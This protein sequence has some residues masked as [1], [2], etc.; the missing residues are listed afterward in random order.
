MVSVP[1]SFVTIHPLPCSFHATR[2]L[3]ASCLIHLLLF[4]PIFLVLSVQAP[5]TG[6]KGLGAKALEKKL[7]PNVLTFGNAQQVDLAVKFVHET[8]TKTRGRSF[9]FFLKQCGYVQCILGSM[10]VISGQ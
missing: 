1:P 7:E 8:L 9:D 10:N 6:V 2:H 3:L 5:L 4:F